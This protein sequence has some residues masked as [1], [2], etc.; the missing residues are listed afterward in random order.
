MNVPGSQVTTAWV[1]DECRA[2][3]GTEGA[4]REA[5]ERLV[6]E[7]LACNPERHPPGTR[8]HFTLTRERASTPEGQ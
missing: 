3:R 2:N 7:Y 1:T 8:W 5:V 4:A 6:Q